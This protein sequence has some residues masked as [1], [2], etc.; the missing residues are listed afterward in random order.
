MKWC[1]TRDV[2]MLTSKHKTSSF[3]TVKSKGRNT[4]KLNPDVVIDYNIYKAEHGDQLVYY[5]LFHRKTVK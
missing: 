1:D 2:Y 4:Y 5:Y 3:V